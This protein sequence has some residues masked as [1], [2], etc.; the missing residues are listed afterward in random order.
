MR[1]GV[2]ADTHGLLRPEASSFL[3]GADHIVHA[4]DIG[5][6]AILAE[7]AVLAPVL[8]VRGNNDVGAWA[9]RLPEALAVELDGLECYV[10]HDRS[11][12]SRHPAPSGTQVV[13][14]G[15]SHRPLLQAEGG[16][17]Y[18]NPGSAGR[19]RFK[20]PIA[21]GEV[22]IEERAIEARI[23]DLASRQLLASRR[24]TRPRDRS[25]INW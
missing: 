15:H 24:G 20:L 1:I 16:T 4:G 11:D 7:L 5:A 9:A 23:I 10:I 18:M 25:H 6:A 17:L 13:L 8:A 2:I 19:R 21:I 14:M 12:L 3:R 22:L